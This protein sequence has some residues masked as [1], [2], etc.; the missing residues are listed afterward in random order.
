MPALVAAFM[1]VILLGVNVGQYLFNNKKWVVQPALVA[2]RSGARMFSYNPRIAILMNRLEAGSIYDRNG[3]LLAT[4]KVSQLLEQ[5]QILTQSGIQ[6]QELTAL[7]RKRY[8]RYYPF[9]DHMFFWTGDAN[10]GVFNGSLNGYF[11]E[12]RLQ[13]ELRGFSTSEKYMTVRASRFREHPLLP[14]GS[15]EMNVVHRDYSALSYMLLAGVNSAEVDSFKKRNRD[16]Q[17]SMDAALQTALQ[18]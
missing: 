3:R 9:G 12:Y 16:V 2:D 8:S 10:T 6:S 14:A 15:R 7:S 1:G 13:A 11:A 17:L 5:R 4:S 18:N